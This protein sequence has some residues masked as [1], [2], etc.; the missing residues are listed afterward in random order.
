MKTKLVI[1]ILL[2]PVMCIAQRFF[3]KLSSGNPELPDGWPVETSNPLP[4]SET[5][6]PAGWS[7]NWTKS[8]LN[9]RIETLRPA[10]EAIQQAQVTAKQNAESARR[11][12]LGDLFRDFHAYEQGWTDG[13][14]YNAAT[15]QVII[16][17]HNAALL[18][19]KPMLKDLYDSRS[20]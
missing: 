7:T 20:E 8:Q 14:N 5:S 13:T 12:L 17:K 1:A 2:V 3:V 11:A 6:V 9:Q 16:R 10:Y 4:D 18:L 19:L 15:L